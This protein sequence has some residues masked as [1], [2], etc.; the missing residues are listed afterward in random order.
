MVI[1]FKFYFFCNEIG[2]VT[3][4]VFPTISSIE[5]QNHSCV[6]DGESSEAQ[7]A[8]HFAPENCSWEEP[9]NH[10]G[11][12]A[13]AL[14]HTKIM[15]SSKGRLSDSVG[16]GFAEFEN[17]EK[18]NPL[19]AKY[20]SSRRSI[21]SSDVTAL[22][23]SNQNGGGGQEKNASQW[24]VRFDWALVEWNVFALFYAPPSNSDDYRGWRWPS[25][26]GAQGA[27]T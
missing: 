13:V 7:V 22:V 18:S 27:V 4:V 8:N 6:V 9:F 12:W 16:I 19:L 20:P 10:L 5:H 3:W 1:L 25:R 14:R 2:A 26:W 17:G 11:G 21:L 15:N 24:I 23:I